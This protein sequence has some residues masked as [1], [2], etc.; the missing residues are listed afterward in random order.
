[1]QRRHFFHAIES[2]HAN[3]VGKHHL[4]FQSSSFEA[5]QIVRKFAMAAADA[6]APVQPDPKTA[7]SINDFVV[8]TVDGM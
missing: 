3:L 8:K 1:M 2:V 7:T 5:S 4:C 6:T